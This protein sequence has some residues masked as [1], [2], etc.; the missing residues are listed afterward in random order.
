[1]PDEPRKMRGLLMR[2]SPFGHETKASVLHQR[3]KI[4]QEEAERRHDGEERS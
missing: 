4:A 2:D 3:A 1:L